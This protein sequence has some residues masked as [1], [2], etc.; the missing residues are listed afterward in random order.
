MAATIFVALAFVPT[1]AGAAQ[2][3]ARYLMGTVCEVAVGVPTS[4]SEFLGVPRSSSE[5]TGLPRNPRNPRNSEELA[6]IDLAFAEAERIEGFLST[7]KPESELSR[8]N[9]GEIDATSPELAALLAE[10][11]EWSRRT[12]GAF[13]PLVRPLI[14]AWKTREDGAV[15]ARAA[16]DAALA[17]MH[18]GA[19]GAQ[20]EEGAFGK[21]YA[22][23]R[24]LAKLT[25]AEAMIDFGGQLIV[26]GSRRVGIA[27][28]EDRQ[29]PVVELTLSDAS[30]STSSGSEKTFTV[31]GK[32]FSHILD[33]RTGQAL[34]PR[35]SVSVI[36]ERAL[37]ADILSTALYVMGEDDGLRWANANGVAAL[38]LTTTHQLRLSNAA[39]ERVRG[40][41]ILDRNYR[42]K[43]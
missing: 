8:L 14:D 7:W 15:P 29:R 34:P 2:H 31:D 30:L 24:M 22:L 39:R 19:A 3:R 38:F 28:P 35:G 10:T 18:A 36:A 33:P 40:L 5:G 32:R 4:S 23:D 26:R 21:G 16:I 11:L 43:D 1:I 27:D 12:D 17:K 41:A 37:T 9:A 13:H 20:F 25:S 42:L 6:E